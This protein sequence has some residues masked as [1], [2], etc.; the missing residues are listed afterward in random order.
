MYFFLSFNQFKIGIGSFGSVGDAMW[1]G[2]KR[3]PEPKEAGDEAA[4]VKASENS[5]RNAKGIKMENVA[6]SR[7]ISH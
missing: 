5:T 6:K 7:I 3:A 1:N 2:N 4:T